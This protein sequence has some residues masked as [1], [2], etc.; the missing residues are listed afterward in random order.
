[1]MSCV[2]QGC[3]NDSKTGQLLLISLDH[4]NSVVD[5]IIQ[6]LSFATSAL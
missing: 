5:F 6:G 3:R 4:V 2:I 1:M